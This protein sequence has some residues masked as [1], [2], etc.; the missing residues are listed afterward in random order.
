MSGMQGI[1]ISDTN[2]EKGEETVREVKAAMVHPEGKV[3]FI[4]AD[5]VQDGQVE[6][7]MTKAFQEMGSLHILVN[8]AGVMLGEDD[9]PTNTPEWVYKTT[10]DVNVLGPYL[11]MKH[12]LPLMQKSGGGSIVNVGSLVAYV[13]SATPQTLYTASKGAVVAMSRELGVVYARD[14]IRINCINPGPI[15]TELMTKFL[16]T[17]EKIARRFVHNPMG[18]LGEAFEI[19]QGISFLASHESSI[20]TA[21]NMVCDMGITA[22]YVTPE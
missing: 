15:R 9:M 12:A 5:V 17:E 16:N 20:M 3:I 11:C 7:L 13:G 22:A 6:S 14:N 19:A 18:R 10:F 2:A 1:V 8:N 4:Q 21:S